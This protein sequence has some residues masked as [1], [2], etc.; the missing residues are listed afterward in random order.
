[1]RQPIK[2]YR[3][4]RDTKPVEELSVSAILRLSP[5]PEIGEGFRE[6]FEAFLARKVGWS[7]KAFLR[8]KVLGQAKRAELER[9]GR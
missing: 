8:R 1:M 2:R 9:V 3:V 6:W 5:L 7:V 4:S